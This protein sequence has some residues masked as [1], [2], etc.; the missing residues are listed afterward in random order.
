MASSSSLMRTDAAAVA[1]PRT[2]SAA[3]RNDYDT[4]SGVR[5][6]RSR[7]ISSTVI[8]SA[9][10]DTTVATGTHNPRIVGTPPLTRG[11]W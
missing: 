1:V 6:E 3:Y 8:P 10:I 7:Q 5:S 2:V 9:T 4:S 11:Q